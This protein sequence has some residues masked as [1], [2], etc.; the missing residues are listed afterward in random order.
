MHVFE[1]QRYRLDHRI[2]FSSLQE[3]I[4]YKNVTDIISIEVEK[5]QD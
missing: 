1:R 3:R 4:L 2:V 5:F